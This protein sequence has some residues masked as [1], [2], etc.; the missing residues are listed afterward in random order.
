MNINSPITELKGVGEKTKDLF[1]KAGVYTVGDILLRFPRSYVKY[2]AITDIDELKDINTD[3]KYAIHACIRNKVINKKTTRMLVSLLD[4]GDYGHK[5]Q[6]VWFRSPYIKNTIIPGKHYI[7][8]GKISVRDDKYSME[9]PDIY[10]VEKYSALEGTL[11]PVYSLSNGIKN[12]MMTKTIRSAL[13]FDDL[14]GDYIPSSIR[15]ENH[16]CEYNYAIKQIHF[17]DSIETLI[18]AR[19]RLVFDEFFLFIMGMQYQKEQQVKAPNNFEFMN[20]EFIDDL[21]SKLPFSL[22]DAQLKTIKEIRNDMCSDFSMQ[23]LVQ[24]DV[25]SGKTII[26]FLLMAWCSLNGY[27]SAIMA[28]TEVLATQHYETFTSLVRD[29]NLNYQVILLTGSMTAKQKRDAYEKMQ[30]FPNAMIIG[31][32]ALIQEKAM[33]DNLALVI[34]DEQHRFGVKQRDTF[35]QKGDS[36]HILVMS[37]TPIPRTLAIIIYGDMDI[38]VIDEVPAKRLPIKNCVVNSSYRPK[39]YEF[40]QNEINNGHQVYIICPLVEETENLEGEN[41][42]DYAKKLRELLPEDIK[43]GVLHGKMKNSLKNEV[44]EAFAANKIQILISTTVVEVGV[45]VPN[46]TVMMIENADRFGLA[47]LHQLRGRVGRGDAQSYCI[48]INTSHSKTAQKRLDILNKSN[49]GFFIASEDLK[50]RGPGDFFGIRQ[51]GDL[52]FQLGDIYQDASILQKAA[53]SVK[54]ILSE[55]P[56]LESEQHKI[57]KHHMDRFMENQLKKMNL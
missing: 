56:D 7:F 8:Y 36:P 51:S 1:A 4:I 49:D 5:I 39:A 41:V 34:T 22:T 9:Q 13:A 32:H 35:S 16:Y 12:T 55:D 37:A 15:M 50:L 17:P 40:M 26:A 24:G 28:P 38:S 44:M 48:M 29:F 43:L 45:N 54:E 33:Y 19:E 53:D 18:R 10:E 23:R 46:A 21:I 2:P 3:E 27:Q 57:L 20:P 6:L 30:L 14:F 31:T 47:Q 25:G 52:A 42:V 11:Q